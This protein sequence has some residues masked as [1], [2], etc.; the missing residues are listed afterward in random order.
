MKH[1]GKNILIGIIIVINHSKFVHCFFSLAVF[2]V[3][4]VTFVCRWMYPFVLLSRLVISRM[5]L[6]PALFE[7]FS[8]IYRL[9]NLSRCFL[10]IF[11]YWRDT[12]F[13]YLLFFSDIGMSSVCHF[14]MPPTRF[15]LDWLL[16]LM[17]IS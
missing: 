6:F 9:L 10:S 15:A 3:I 5:A 13:K 8:F 12:L 14:R 16:L 1:L 17:R 11:Y 2:S 4:S 7:L